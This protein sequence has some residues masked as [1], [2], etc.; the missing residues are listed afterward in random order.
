MRSLAWLLAIT[1]CNAAFDIDKTELEPT[2]TLPDGDQDGVPDADDNCPAVANGTQADEDR[3]T[4]GDA[5]D[6]CPLIANTEQE[7]NGDDDPLGDLCDPHP[8]TSGDCPILVETFEDPASL[9]QNWTLY[10]YVTGASPSTPAADAHA[11]VVPHGVHLVAGE[12]M[13]EIALLV[14][15][16]GGTDPH[17]MFD[18]QLVGTATFTSGALYVGTNLRDDRVGE[19]GAFCGIRVSA[20][21]PTESLRFYG[22]TSSNGTTG[23]LDVD[24]INGTTYI[25]MASVDV[26]GNP[27]IACRLDYGVSTGFLSL[28][29]LTGVLNAG[30]PGAVVD[31]EEATI[32]AIELTHFQPG[33]PCPAVLLR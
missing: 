24:H 26:D 27:L 33:V 18:A 7:R 21:R 14:R 22:T 30:V 29:M 28:M 6:N 13:A 8:V 3:D 17:Q 10:S 11:D 31:S 20:T 9:A 4:I 23:R 25:R 32:D 19:T 5:C 12:P 2:V 16:L 15:D 1:A